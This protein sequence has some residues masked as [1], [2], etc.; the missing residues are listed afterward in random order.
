MP[1]APSCRTLHSPLRLFPRLLL[2]GRSENPAREGVPPG[3]GLRV[4][5]LR[6]AVWRDVEDRALTPQLRRFG[7]LDLGPVPLQRRFD[8]EG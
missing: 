6:Y 7:Q 4:D 3:A 8:Q 1:D 2:W 5:P